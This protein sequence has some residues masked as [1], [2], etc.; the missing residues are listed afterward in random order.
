M[1]YQIPSDAEPRTFCKNDDTHTRFVAYGHKPVLWVVDEDGNYIEDIEEP[2]PK[3]GLTPIRTFDRER[4]V[5]CEQCG[6]EVE[7]YYVDKKGTAYFE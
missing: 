5:L 2:D 6:G 7:V 1:V 4:G 3:W